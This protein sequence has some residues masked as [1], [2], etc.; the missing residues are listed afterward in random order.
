MDPHV[1]A[2]VARRDMHL[3]VITRPIGFQKNLK[4]ITH[5]PKI[6][7]IPGR[8]R[9]NLP[10][11]QIG[12]HQQGLGTPDDPHRARGKAWQLTANLSESD[13]QGVFQ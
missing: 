11:P 2:M 10:V 1:H 4:N 8:A 6:L 7:R 9:E 12:P 5:L 3:G 13:G